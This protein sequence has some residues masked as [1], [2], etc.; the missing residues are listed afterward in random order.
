ME[1]IKSQNKILHK[2]GF[3][4]GQNNKKIYFEKHEILNSKASIVISHGFCESTQ[5]Y[6]ELIKIFND[7]NYSVYILDHRGHGKSQKLGKYKNQINVEKFE[8]YI[9][10]LKLFIDKEILP[11]N[12][13]LYLFAHSMGGAIGSLFLEKYNNYFNKAILS[14]PMMTIDTGKYGQV[15]S[16]IIA[17][18][19][20]LL[21]KGDEYVLGH[22]P[23]NSKENLKDSGTSSEKRYK[24]YFNKQLENEYLQTSGASFRWLKESLKATKKLIK[25]ENTSKVA[26]PVLL[27]QSGKDTFVKPKGQN[28]FAQNAKQCTIRLFEEAKHEIY[29]ERDEIFNKYINEVIDFYNND[30]NKKYN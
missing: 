26:I 13:E 23:F 15:L 10:D 8:Y 30:L 11:N 24:A 16:E 19:F 1:S 9:E 12:K 27:F 5:K 22:G 4:I 29:F 2:K 25:K 3:F 20:C 17:N 28:K 21:G 18:I 14:S 6:V 7:N